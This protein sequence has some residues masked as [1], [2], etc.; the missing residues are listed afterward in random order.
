M[1]DGEGGKREIRRSAQE[2]LVTSTDAMIGISDLL[3]RT[4]EEGLTHNIYMEWG[5]G[6]E[7]QSSIGIQRKFS[8][9]DIL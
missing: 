4:L 9:L 7:R 8:F 5:Q 2:Y 6:H 1:F 3:Q